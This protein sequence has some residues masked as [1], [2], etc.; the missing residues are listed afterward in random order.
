M[1]TLARDP[2]PVLEVRLPTSAACWS[3]LK[4]WT[5]SGPVDTGSFVRSF[6]TWLTLPPWER[7]PALWGLYHPEDSERSV[8]GVS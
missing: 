5:S 3:A 4:L 6:R 7:E 2:V 8:L 1:D